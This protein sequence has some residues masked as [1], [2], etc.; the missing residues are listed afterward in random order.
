MQKTT[1]L[2]ETELTNTHPYIAKLKEGRYFDVPKEYLNHPRIAHFYNQEKVLFTLLDDVESYEDCIKKLHRINNSIGLETYLN[3]FEANH[4]QSLIRIGHTSKDAAEEAHT[5]SKVARKLWY[6]MKTDF[7]N[8]EEI[9]KERVAYIQSLGDYLHN[10]H[11]IR[12][13]IDLMMIIKDLAMGTDGSG[14]DMDLAF[15][16]NVENNAAARSI[17][18]NAIEPIIANFEPESGVNH[19]KDTSHID[20]KDQ[21]Y[22]TDWLRSIADQPSLHEQILE[23]I[24]GGFKTNTY[25]RRFLTENIFGVMD[26]HHL[27]VPIYPISKKGIYDELME[28]F[29]PLVPYKQNNILQTDE[30]AGVVNA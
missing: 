10:D 22:A 20:W 16:F 21:V 15:A 23:Q 27:S 4:R 8:I 7:D 9:H 13:I 30:L 29:T 19:P 25:A 17:A 18:I 26:G 11:N 28:K 1:K 24:P 6:R 14:S 2:P 12:K 5:I 3:D